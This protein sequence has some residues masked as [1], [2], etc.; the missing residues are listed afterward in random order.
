MPTA[1]SRGTDE[2]KSDKTPLGFLSTKHTIGNLS[3]KKTFDEENSSSFTHTYDKRNLNITPS[4]DLDRTANII[5]TLQNSPPKV[6]NK[7]EKKPITKLPNTNSSSSKK[8]IP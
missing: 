1:P 3:H 8:Q 7:S 5:T 4:E 2:Q 6:I